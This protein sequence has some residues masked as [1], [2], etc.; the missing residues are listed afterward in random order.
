MPNTFALLG[1]K[2]SVIT[3]NVEVDCVISNQWETGYIV[4]VTIKNSSDKPIEDW[5]MVFSLPKEIKNI[6][7]GR[8]AKSQTGGYRIQNLGYNGNIKPRES[9]SFGFE[10]ATKNFEV[11]YPEQIII[12]QMVVS[13]CKAFM[14]QQGYTFA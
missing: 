2:E 6:W 8:I 13:I 10:C 12:N 7:N 5:E 11:I 4:D 9:V 1:I 3:G 14:F